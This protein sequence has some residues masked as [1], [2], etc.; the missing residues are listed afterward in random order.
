MAV[1]TRDEIM[2]ILDELTKDHSDDRT[3]E[4]I[5]DITD[6]VN[7][8]GEAEDWRTRYEELDQKW[9]SRYRERFFEGGREGE[10]EDVDTIDTKETKRTYEELFK[11]E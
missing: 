7:A 10:D 5:E 6:T 4:I 8:Y 9:R 11:E 2:S 3:L 1:R